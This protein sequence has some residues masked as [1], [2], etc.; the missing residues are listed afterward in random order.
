M[1]PQMI[2][3]KFTQMLTGKAPK[4]EG[5]TQ[6]RR[7]E[8]TSTCDRG[9]AAAEPVVI[10]AAAPTKMIKKRGESRREERAV[11]W[12]ARAEAGAR[13]VGQAEGDAAAD[14]HGQVHADADR[15]GAQERGAHAAAAQGGDL[16]VRQR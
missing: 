16:Y 3:A 2:M 11:G 14:D 15:Q 7:K 10:A 13:R 6:R 4:N 12:P 1:L 9:E 8:A 5:L